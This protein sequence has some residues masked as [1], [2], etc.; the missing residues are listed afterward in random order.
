[1]KS[2]YMKSY[3]MISLGE[4]RSQMLGSA[5]G[6]ACFSCARVRMYAQNLGYLRAGAR[7]PNITK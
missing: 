3:Y 1:M 5:S 7:C 6:H 2:Y 4:N